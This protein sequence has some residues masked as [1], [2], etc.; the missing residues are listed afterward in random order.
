MTDWPANLDSFKRVVA[1]ANEA[2]PTIVIA[3]QSTTFAK[4]NPTL[5]MSRFADVLQD[6]IVNRGLTNV[7][8]VSIGNEPNT[9]NNAGN[10][11][12]TPP[13]Y[14][15]LY[16]ALDAELRARRLR[17]QLGLIGGDLVQNTGGTAT[18]AACGG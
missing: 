9:V 16:R 1:L 7:R 10:P 15:A 14:E 8:W 12:I 13:Q 11:A 4:T 2:G 5:R 6:L 18:S 3:Y 17:T